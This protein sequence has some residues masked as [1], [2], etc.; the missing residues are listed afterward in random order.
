MRSKQIKIICSSDSEFSFIP[1]LFSPLSYL[2]SSIVIWWFFEKMLVLINKE[3]KYK[4]NFG[5]DKEK[6]NYS[7]TLKKKNHIWNH[8]NSYILMIIIIIFFFQ[9]DFNRYSQY[10]IGKFTIIHGLQ[11]IKFRHG[12]LSFSSI[13]GHTH[14]ISY[15]SIFWEIF[16]VNFNFCKFKDDWFYI[17]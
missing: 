15:R 8:P 14:F 3:S 1:S 13:F 2:P 5:A 16:F 9:L 12:R 17:L 11:F 7:I 6:S 4:E 10:K